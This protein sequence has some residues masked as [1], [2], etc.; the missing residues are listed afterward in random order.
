MELIYWY[1]FCCMVVAG[2]SLVDLYHP[3][4]SKREMPWDTRLIFYVTFYIIALLAAPLLVYPCL[5]KLKGVEF[6][7]AIEK[8]LFS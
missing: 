5:A 7:N 1:G 2:M 4:L 6:R 3:V 8:A